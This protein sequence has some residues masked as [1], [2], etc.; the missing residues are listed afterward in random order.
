MEPLFVALSFFCLAVRV[1]AHVLSLAV[2][3]LEGQE[4]HVW[5]SAE[6]DT[7]SSFTTALGEKDSQL[8]VL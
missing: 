5:L 8:H 4:Q 7:P 1:H 2:L 3:V 6:Q